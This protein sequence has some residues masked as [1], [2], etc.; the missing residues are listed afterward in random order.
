MAAV[1]AMDHG[2]FVATFGRIVEHA[3]WVAEAAWQRGPFADRGRLHAAMV[4][5]IEAAEPM[6]Q[7]ALIR[8]HPDLAGRAAI[9]GELTPAS[10]EEQASSGIDRCS[11]AEYERFRELTEAYKARFGFPFIMAVRQST[12]PDILEAF[13]RRL[14]NDPVQERA[15]AT[16]EI[17]RIAQ[18]RLE[19][20]VED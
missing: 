8:G 14:E 5:T 4:Q 1:R 20:L 18:L 12:V 9:R 19:Q 7:L 3:P 13:A 10:R 16:G 2:T 6:A 17:G 15:R 11:P